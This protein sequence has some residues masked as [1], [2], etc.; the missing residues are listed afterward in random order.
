[1]VEENPIDLNNT[2]KSHEK[3]LESLGIKKIEDE[4]SSTQKELEALIK[5]REEL[6]E[7]INKIPK[8]EKGG[9]KKEIKNKDYLKIEG[10]IKEIDKHIKRLKNKIKKSQE[11]LDGLREI[12]SNPPKQ[13]DGITKKKKP[14][15]IGKEL[16][17]EGFSLE[18]IETGIETGETEIEKS[19][20]RIQ[21]AKDQFKKAQKILEDAGEDEKETAQEV[22]D[23]AEKEL[24]DA[25]DELINLEKE[26]AR[27]Y[28]E[29][30]KLAESR[31]P[32]AG[33]PPAEPEI[34][35]DESTQP[36]QEEQEKEA[37]Q[38]E[39]SQEKE[40]AVG[41][42]GQEGEP[43]EDIWEGL[44]KKTEQMTIERTNEN[45]ERRK[46][47]LEEKKSAE[48]RLT[49]V[50]KEISEKERSS[51]GKSYDEKSVIEL[52][53][54]P[55]R[56][57]QKELKRR[58]SSLG[59]SINMLEKDIEQGKKF[60]GI[61]KPEEPK[62]KEPEKTPVLEPSP[63]AEVLADKIEGM[64]LDDLKNEWHKND[65]EIGVLSAERKRWFREKEEIEKR[66]P[67]EKDPK[68]KGELKKKA[69]DLKT[70][71]KSSKDK[72]DGIIKL[73]SIIYQRIKELGGDLSKEEEK[74]PDEKFSGYLA[75]LDKETLKTVLSQMTPYDIAKMTSRLDR[76]GQKFIAK[77]LDSKVKKECSEIWNSSN[78]AKNPISNS[79][80]SKIEGLVNQKIQQLKTEQESKE[81]EKEKISDLQKQIGMLED[82]NNRLTLL[83]SARA[84][85]EEGMRLAKI[86]EN[87]N[88]IDNLKKELEKYLPAKPVSQPPTPPAPPPAPPFQPPAPPSQ[89][90]SQPP[91]PPSQP[92]TPPSQ[93][94]IPPQGPSQPPSMP[95]EIPDEN[96]FLRMSEKR[97]GSY[98]FN[99]REALG[100]F[101]DLAGKGEKLRNKLWMKTIGRARQAWN[102]WRFGVY[103]QKSRANSKQLA[104]YNEDINNYQNDLN[105]VNN[106]IEALKSSGMDIINGIYSPEYLDLISERDGLL[107]DI[108]SI[109]KTM[110]PIRA[111]V[112]RGNR[113]KSAFYNN[114]T[115]LHKETGLR[116]DTHLDPVKDRI[117]GLEMERR[118][119]EEVIAAK[120]EKI[121]A[122]DIRINQLDE[123]RRSQKGWNTRRALL[124]QLGRMR[125][126]Q[127]KSIRMVDNLEKQIRRI[128]R[129]LNKLSREAGYWV[130]LS[131]EFANQKSLE[132]MPTGERVRI[133]PEK[134]MAENR[135]FYPEST[136]IFEENP[137]AVYEGIDRRE[138]AKKEQIE[139]AMDLWRDQ[140]GNMT[141]GGRKIMG[142]F[143]DS[144][145]ISKSQFNGIF[146]DITDVVLNPNIPREQK[147][148]MIN[149]FLNYIYEGRGGSQEEV[150]NIKRFIGQ[151]LDTVLNIV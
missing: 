101:E 69:G 4:I 91:K 38:P 94:P 41:Y 71:I 10:D 134:G 54:K 44:K 58:A 133:Q 109:R 147:K 31:A 92:P 70:K 20:E 113:M 1:M 35:S 49:Q 64:P 82:E 151:R 78:L 24:A 33:I 140:I 80:L 37:K 25:M 47:L 141:L 39:P 118:N 106:Q 98:R 48:D 29:K 66:V 108:S 100:R 143:F 27:L 22:V 60:F 43:P 111:R 26:L 115:A 139:E 12:F 62:I 36:P 129:P 6:R 99:D 7:Q 119:I 120:R 11:K 17:G 9:G 50:E 123:K 144:P 81:S 30:E 131:Y 32:E 96:R 105:T 59:G 112:D 2:E 88:K 138:E 51:L 122:Q 136:R 107:A 102:G 63:K 95:S 137:T 5:R 103:D 73:N 149:N 93:P 128:D 126:E 130:S 114:L 117:S 57:L 28:S 110:E 52:E 42:P 89:P 55:L 127:K 75:S 86:K 135:G 132:I 34:N 124:R 16:A 83:P 145:I 148:E 14:E 56:I 46:E 84:M 74:L 45:I 61:Q 90:P 23:E 146:E 104:G 18:E 53:L 72:S 13:V 125:E 87:Q 19:K 68:K 121:Q 8:T 97:L 21:S 77:L 150:E 15:N 65:A 79:E 67:K 3:G 85:Q 116:I 76:E 142:S 40:S